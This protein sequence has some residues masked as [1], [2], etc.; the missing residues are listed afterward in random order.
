MITIGKVTAV[1]PTEKG[2][3]ATMSIDSKFKI[4]LDSVANVHSVSAVGE[5]YLD[6]VSE[7]KAHGVLFAGADHD[8]GH[9]AE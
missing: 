7:G 8:Q 3:E 2:A 6:L 4:P 1:E 9:G 5:Q